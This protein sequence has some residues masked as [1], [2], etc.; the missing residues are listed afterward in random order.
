MAKGPPTLFSFRAPKTI[1]PALLNPLTYSFT[2]WHFHQMQLFKNMSN[3]TQKAK[4]ISISSALSTLTSSFFVSLPSRGRFR[5]NTHTYIE[6][7]SFFLD[8]SDV[9]IDHRLL[10]CVLIGFTVTLQLQFDWI[11]NFESQA[12]VMNYYFD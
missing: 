3:I 8:V 2:M 10:V 11:L 7:G 6:S 9:N 5:S 12:T 1:G 4:L